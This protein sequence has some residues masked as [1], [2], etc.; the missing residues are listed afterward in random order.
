MGEVRAVIHIA[1]GMAEHAIRYSRF[2]SELTAAG[3]AVFAHDYRGHG[4]TKADGC[5]PR[6]I[7]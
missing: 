4:F 3:Y 2:A 6:C 5:T 7:C 1:H